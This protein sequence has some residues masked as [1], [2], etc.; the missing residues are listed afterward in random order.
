MSGA[1]LDEQPT[2]VGYEDRQLF[3]K[4]FTRITVLNLNRPF[5]ILYI[6]F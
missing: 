5:Q 4:Y 3:D 1:R 6:L 2:Y